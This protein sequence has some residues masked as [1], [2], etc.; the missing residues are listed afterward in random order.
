MTLRLADLLEPQVAADLEL[1]RLFREIEM[2]LVE[3]L[4]DMES[5]GVTLDTA[6]LAALSRDLH[7]QAEDLARQIYDLAGHPFSINSPK[8]VA[9][10]LFNEIGLQSQGKTASGSAGKNHIPQE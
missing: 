2:P 8:Q 4:D 7:A 10:V 1:D 3:V 9:D 6:A 5:E